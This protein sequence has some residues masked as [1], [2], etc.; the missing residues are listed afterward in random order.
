MVGLGGK[1]LKEERRA[2]NHRLYGISEALHHHMAVTML[3]LE[4]QE[5]IVCF[6]LRLD[7]NPSGKQD[8]IVLPSNRHFA[9]KQWS[10][11]RS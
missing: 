10:A 1:G 3:K 9:T 8:S 2:D 4:R 6:Y 5:Q 11:V 7:T